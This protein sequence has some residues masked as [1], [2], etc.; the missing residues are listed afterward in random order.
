MN[1]ATPALRLEN[2]SK[3]FGRIKAVDDLSLEVYPGEMVGFLGPNGAGKSTTLFMIAGL[4]HPAGGK[5]EIFGHDIRTMFKEAMA[6][7]G[8]MVETPAFYNYLSARKNLE[9]AARLRGNVN[10]K[11][12]DL[13]LERIGLEKR[14]KDKVGTFSLGMRQRLGL[15]LTLLGSPRMLL[16]DEPTNGLDPEATRDILTL[17]KEKVRREQLAVFLSSHLLYEVEEFCDRVVVINNGQLIVTGP[18]KEIL[19]SATPACRPRTLKEFFFSVTGESS[20][21]K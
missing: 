8:T 17:L 5:I 15:G 10:R 12:I 9:L 16:L 7:V 2:L 13:I 4:V 21:A 11:E 14:Q 1:S 19:A 20:D 18:V 6:R 3:T